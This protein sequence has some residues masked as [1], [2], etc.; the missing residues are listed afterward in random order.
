MSKDFYIK[1]VLTTAQ[2]RSKRLRTSGSGY[3]V[4]GSGR[5]QGTSS[6]GSVTSVEDINKGVAA[7]GWGNHA[8]EGYLKSIDYNMVVEALGYTP[9]DGVRGLQRPQIKIVRGLDHDGI[10]MD[11]SLIANH[12]LKTPGGPS[13]ACFVLM[14]YC[15]R[16]GK[17]YTKPD[18]IQYREK[19]GEAR[20]RLAT[21]APLTFSGIVTLDTLRLHILHNYICIYGSAL[22]TSLTLGQFAAADVARFGRLAR[23]SGTLVDFKEKTHSSRLFGIAVRYTNPE[24]TPLVSGSLAETTRNI[25]GTPR[26]IYTDIA[27]IRV[28]VGQDMDD[29]N[30][31]G[32]Q[33]G[34]G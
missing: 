29:I 2:P 26:Y 33:L 6:G 19:W 4:S 9:A 21:N 24:F 27:P 8:Q 13:D 32:F 23:Y 22:P 15:K 28:T 12:P 10:L 7:Y 17:W 1:T 18:Y 16:R 3:V 25:G 30:T 14:V 31:I 11:P 34:V 5:Q 20:G